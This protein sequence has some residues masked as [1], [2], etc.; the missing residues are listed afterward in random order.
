VAEEVEMLRWCIGSLA[1]LERGEMVSL[2]L[3][4]DA[5]DATEFVRFDQ[6]RVRR[7]LTRIAADLDT[8]AVTG[9][10]LTRRA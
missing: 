1:Q 10:L 8:L 5:E 3:R 7:V 6:A 9:L 2:N 4:P